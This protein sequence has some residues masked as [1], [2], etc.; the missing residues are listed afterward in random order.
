MNFTIDENN[1]VNKDNETIYNNYL[2]QI[3]HITFLR[4][5]QSLSTVEELDHKEAIPIPISTYD[6]CES[7]FLNKINKKLE[8]FYMLKEDLSNLI[9]NLSLENKQI[10]DNIKILESSLCNYK[11]KYNNINYFLKLLEKTKNKTNIIYY[12]TQID[13]EQLKYNNNFNKLSQLYETIVQINGF[14]KNT[15]IYIDIV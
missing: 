4:I 2:S 14:I 7:T 6:E 15:K 13:N 1:R 10:S 3:D 12:Q 5:G 11:L 9:N 8:T